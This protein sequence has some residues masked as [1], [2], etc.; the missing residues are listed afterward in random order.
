[1]KL[2]YA[3]QNIDRSEDNRDSFGASF[4]REMGFPGGEYHVNSEAVEELIQSYWLARHNCTDTWVGARVYFFKD[5]PLAV[6]TQAGRKCDEEFSF[7][8]REI[9]LA[10]HEALSKL[11]VEEPPHCDIIDMEEEIGESYG[12]SFYNGIIDTDALF[13]GE[14]VTILRKESQE[15][16]QKLSNTDSYLYKK[17]VIQTASGEIKEV[18]LSDLKFPFRVKK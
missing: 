3:I 11:L 2:S 6:S 5:Q 16:R 8:S 13:A 14:P 15:A 17:A 18:D 7:V 4:Y 10:A 12:I 9:F 1:M